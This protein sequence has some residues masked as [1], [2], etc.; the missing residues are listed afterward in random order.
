MSKPNIYI[1]KGVPTCAS[2]LRIECNEEL[3]YFN[4]ILLS[5]DNPGVRTRKLNKLLDVLII[6]R[7]GV[8]VLFSFHFLVSSRALSHMTPNILFSCP[9]EINPET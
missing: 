6:L 8:V 3:Y 4:N 9:T 1:N 5:A 2:G 7:S